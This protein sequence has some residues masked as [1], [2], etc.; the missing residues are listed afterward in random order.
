M[1]I[2]A[3]IASGLIRGYQLLLRPLLPAACRFEPSCSEYAR[4]A[5]SRHGLVRGGWLAMRRLGRCQPFH[6][7]AVTLDGGAVQFDN[8]GDTP[9]PVLGVTVT[10]NNGT[11][12]VSGGNTLPWAGGITGAAGVNMTKS[13]GGTLVLNSENNLGGASL[14]INMSGGVLKPS[15]AYTSLASTHA[16]TLG[17]KSGGFDVPACVP[18]RERCRVA[19]ALRRAPRRKRALPRAFRFPIDRRHRSRRAG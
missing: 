11:F 4:E 9:S 2:G 8:N 1:S 7:G 6:P 19:M 17:S 5:L 14:P 3:Q 12:I 18:H 16:I 15:A 13:G 10:A